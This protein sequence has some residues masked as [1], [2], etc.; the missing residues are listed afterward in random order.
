MKNE[1]LKEQHAFVNWAEEKGI[2]ISAI[3]N[4]SYTPHAKTRAKNTYEGL[5]PGVPDLIMVI[6][7][8]YRKNGMGKTI[9]VEMKKPKGGVTSK[10]QKEWNKA[11]SE[12]EGVEAAVCNT[13]ERAIAFI[14]SFIEVEPKLDFTYI[15]NLAK[16]DP[17]W[18]PRNQPPN[19][20]KGV[21]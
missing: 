2:M 16:G 7:K 8:K 17:S 4:G 21:Q 10:K 9:L 20:L 18:K 14:Q 15:N 12:S 3:T 19:H 6:P 1:E 5:R 11:L 13:A